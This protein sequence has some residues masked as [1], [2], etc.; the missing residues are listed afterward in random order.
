M[1]LYEH[2]GFPNPR[3]I[4]V[5]LHEKGA[6]IERVPVDVMKGEHRTDAFKTKNPFATVP[7]LELDDGTV[8]TECSSIS[9]HLETTFPTPALLGTTDQEK[10][11]VDLW[12][13]R[14]EQAILNNLA[15]YF[16]HATD[17]LGELEL[18]QNA[19]WGRHCLD[20]ALAT[21]EIVDAE[22][23]GKDYIAGSFSIADITALCALDFAQFMKV[24][25][26]DHLHNV[27]QWHARLKS[28][29]SAQAQ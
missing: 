13:R 26:P 20:Q 24:E 17:G 19:E 14:I 4:A 16:H 28:R 1:K 10:V 29:P 27:H 11:L 3:R 15:T 7:A 22:L 5:F 18:Y 2:A 25:I 23:E 12:Q 8:L 6:D 21:L 9:A